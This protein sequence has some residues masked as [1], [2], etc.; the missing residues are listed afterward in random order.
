MLPDDDL[1]GIFDFCVIEGFRPSEN[2]RIEEWETLA[3]V[4]RRWRSLI[5]QSP[6]RLNL[7]LL[8]TP[9]TRARNTLD[10]WPPFPLIIRDF[11]V[12]HDSESSKLVNVIAAPPTL[13]QRQNSVSDHA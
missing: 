5:F 13:R 8:C 12:D 10:V 6:R 3:H 2:R 1:L 4:C 9:N 7:R 11:E